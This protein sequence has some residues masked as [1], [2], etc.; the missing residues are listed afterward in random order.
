MG[1]CVW[2]G[3]LLSIVNWE[4]SM[5]VW[6]HSHMCVLVCVNDVNTYMHTYSQS[7]LLQNFQCVFFLVLDYRFLFSLFIISFFFFWNEHVIF[8]KKSF[9]LHHAACEILVPP[10]GMEPMPATVKAWSLNHW[11][12]REVPKFIFYF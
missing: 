8:F 6:L 12:L 5:L 11:T 7:G 1:K 9:W 2:H 10:S 3:Q 4:S